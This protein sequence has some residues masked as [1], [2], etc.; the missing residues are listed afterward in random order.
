MRLPAHPSEPSY[1]CYLSILGELA[2]VTPH[3]ESSTILNQPSRG[4]NLHL[5]NTYPQLHLD[6]THRTK[7]DIV[8]QIFTSYVAIGDSLS[9]GLGDFSFL[10]RRV[11]SGWTDRLATLLAREASLEGLEFR[12]ANLAIRGANI[13]AIMGS[14]LDR[15]L[16]MKPD[17]VTVMAGQN[18]FFCKAE[19]LP[20]LER[21]FREGIQ[22][23]LDAGCRVIVS[24]TINPI[25]LVVFRR[26]AKL[27]TAMTAMIERVAKELNVPIHDVHRIDSLAE[28]RYWAEDMVHFSGPGHIKVANKAAEL[29]QLRYR[30]SEFD[31]C[32][33]WIPKRGLVGTSRWVVLH[34]IPF[35]VRRARG[36]TSGD[37]LE[38]KLPELTSYK[39]IA[40]D[41]EPALDYAAARSISSDYLKVS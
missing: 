36:V 31:D 21:V 13:A 37:G 9:E 8:R 28:V 1:P 27:S 5:I 22:K 7:L 14:Q 18:D 11:H 3:G 15:A 25:H 35:M 23:L 20:E 17:L 19:N 30:Q 33:I 26:L 2:E 41:Y 32:E 29:L 40:M 39:G 16:E 4:L 38:P 10:E 24:N 6:L 12:Y 34:V